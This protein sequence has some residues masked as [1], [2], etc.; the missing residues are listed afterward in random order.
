M[1]FHDDVGRVRIY[2]FGLRDSCVAN[3]V[4]GNNGQCGK[5]DAESDDDSLNYMCL[6]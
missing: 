3:V 6:K 2:M 4:N 1:T 5:V